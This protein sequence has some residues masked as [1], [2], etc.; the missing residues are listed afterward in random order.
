MKR[1]LIEK[2]IQNIFRNLSGRKRQKDVQFPDSTSSSSG[3]SKFKSK[4]SGKKRNTM[5]TQVTNPHKNEDST[6]NSK[7]FS[8][9]VADSGDGHEE[10]GYF[11][12][13]DALQLQFR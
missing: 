6:K 9:G 4:L 5:Y 8:N 13:L 7:S 11:N 12:I 3:N 10:T 1:I 2:V